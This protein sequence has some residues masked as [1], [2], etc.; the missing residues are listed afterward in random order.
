MADNFK[1]L[2]VFKPTKI[3]RGYLNAVD[4][5]L[6]CVISRKRKTT[7]VIKNEHQATIIIMTFLKYQICR[8]GL[9]NIVRRTRG[10]KI[11]ALLFVYNSNSID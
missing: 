9:R 11:K 6:P 2:N 5:Q 1:K 3:L 7:P 4:P 10:R 8:F